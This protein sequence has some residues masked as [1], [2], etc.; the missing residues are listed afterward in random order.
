[1]AALRELVTSRGGRLRLAVAAGLGLVL[2]G[3][4]GF[5]LIAYKDQTWAESAAYARTSTTPARAVVVVYSR[6]GHTL[7]AAKE[8]ARTLDADLV[9]V[10]SPD[11][12]QDFAGQRRAS[13]HA[14][15]QRTEATIEHAPVDL[16]GY[17]LVVL[18][19]PTWW[20]RPAVPLWAFVAQN[21]F[22][23]RPVFLLLTGNSRYEEENIARFG[24][25]VAKRGGRLVGHTFIQR[26]RVIWQKSAAEVRA[27]VRAAL[28]RHPGLQPRAR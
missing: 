12:P 15:E 9:P 24:E 7:G 1:M 11:Y 20:Y 27:D 13:A 2:L 18:A 23:G 4:S 25:A 26:G 6:S 21:D 14:D 16:A 3:A 22:G 19:S 8:A 5:G 28:A 10:T 17:E